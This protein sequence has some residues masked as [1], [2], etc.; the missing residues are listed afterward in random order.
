MLNPLPK[1]SSAPAGIMTTLRRWTVVLMASLLCACTAASDSLDSGA[2]GTAIASALPVSAA[3]VPQAAALRTAPRIALVIGND[4]YAN[5]EQLQFPDN[6]A[7]AMAESFRSRGF[8]LVGG[9]AQIDVSSARLH[10]LATRTEGAIRARPGAIVAVYF[11]GHGFAD[12]GHNYLVPTDAPGDSPAVPVSL[13]VIELAQRLNAAGSGLTMMFLDACREY[14]PGH[15]G[16]LVEEPVLNNTF[17]GFATLFGAYAIEPSATSG[18]KHGYYTAA[19]LQA[20]DAGMDRLDDLHLV[21]A[22]HVISTTH[23]RQL[24]VYRQGTHMPNA[25]VRL[26]L[27]DPQTTYAIARQQS[28][29]SGEALATQCAAMSDLRLVVGLAAGNSVF[30]GMRIEPRYEPIDLSTAYGSCSAA[31]SAGRREAAVLRGLALTELLIAL[32]SGNMPPMTLYNNVGA[33]L[34]EAAEGGDALTDFILASVQNSSDTARAGLQLPAGAVSDRLEHAAEQNIPPL[35]GIV[36]LLLWR[37]EFSQQRSNIGLPPNPALGRQLFIRALLSGDPLAQLVGLSLR[38]NKDPSVMNLPLRDGLRRAFSSSSAVGFGFDGFSVHQTLY[39]LALLDAAA[40]ILGPVDTGEVVRL[41][42]EAQPFLASLGQASARAAG[43]PN[44]VD[45]FFA[46][47]ACAL[48]SGRDQ[49]GMPL[50]G[51]VPNRGIA[52]RLLRNISA[53]PPADARMYINRLTATGSCW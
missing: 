22:E 10:E 45:L 42:L 15:G 27:S 12:Q 43:K 20:L 38:I 39:F 3:D 26:G 50:P 25:P 44:A 48:A 40:G 37:P 51:V 5:W 11:S 9:E 41:T 17:I 36:G 24:P 19:L 34:A 1:T 13:S 52:L 33:L 46:L 32:R 14:Q 6:D 2:P 49:S 53:N 21:V 18:E 4:H 8:E 16:G 31:Y 30:A 29:S 47:T 23:A 7:R 28:P 35:T